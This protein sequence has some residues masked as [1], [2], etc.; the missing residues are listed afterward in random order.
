MQDKQERRKGQERKQGRKGN[1][2][3]G[4]SGIWNWRDREGTNGRE[5]AREHEEERGETGKAS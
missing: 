3:Q 5:G 4:D 2:R 1:Q